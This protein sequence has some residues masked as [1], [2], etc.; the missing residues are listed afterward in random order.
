MIVATQQSNDSSGGNL[1]ISITT[2]GPFGH[3][4]AVCSLQALPSLVSTVAI[5]LVVATA[6]VNFVINTTDK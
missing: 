2:V 3:I 1:I 6:A 4:V 5:T